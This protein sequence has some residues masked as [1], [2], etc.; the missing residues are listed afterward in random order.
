MSTSILEPPVTADSRTVGIPRQADP[1][2]RVADT[3]RTPPAP[4]V[5]PLDP[6]DEQ[7]LARLIAC[8]ELAWRQVVERYHRLVAC[9]VRR[10]VSNPSD[11]DEAIQRTWLALWRFSGSVRDASRLPGWLS[12]TARRE[13]LALIRARRHEVLV[14][15]AGRLDTAY[16]PD[17][18][19]LVEQAER[20]KYLRRAVDRLPERQ[21]RLMLELLADRASYDELSTMLD[22]PRGSIGPMRARALRALREM[23]KSLE[24]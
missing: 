16:A 22:I 9:S 8:D 15:D 12:V 11:V 20:A 3:V 17:T 2:G 19:V 14:E 10:V 23:L 4:A 21:R 13:A 24:A 7:L 18:S 5:L 6:S 1:R